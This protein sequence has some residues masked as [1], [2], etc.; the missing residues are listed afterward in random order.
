V[1]DSITE[2]FRSWLRLRY[3]PLHQAVF[4]H[5]FDGGDTS[6][7]LGSHNLTSYRLKK[8]VKDIKDAARAFARND[9]EFLRSVMQ[10][11]EKAGLTMTKR[12]SVLVGAK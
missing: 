12:L 10:A 3:S 6:D 5:R 7:L 9:P 8:I 4:D 11:L 2:S 1:D